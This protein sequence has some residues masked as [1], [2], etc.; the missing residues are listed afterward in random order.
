[1]RIIIN[2]GGANPLAIRRDNGDMKKI[3]DLLQWFVKY[4]GMR[5]INNG[6][7]FSPALI[8]FLFP[9]CQNGS[10]G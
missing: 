9:S 4:T 8:G 5:R 2:H 1:M 3:D 10:G 6:K 7:R